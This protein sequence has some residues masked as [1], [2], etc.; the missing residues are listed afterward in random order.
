MSLLWLGQRDPVARFTAWLMIFTLG[1]VISGLLTWCSI[2]GQLTEMKRAGGDT[3]D[4]AVAATKQ[5]DNASTA[6]ELEKN[7]QI[8]NFRAWL[9]PNDAKLDGPI[10]KG[11]P[12]KYTISYQN[13]GREPAQGFQSDI[14][15]FVTNERDELAGAYAFRMGNFEQKCLATPAMLGARVIYP[16]TGFASYELHGTLPAEQV[17]E[18]VVTGAKSIAIQGCFAYSTA[19]KDHHS[20]Y[21][22]W[23]NARKS[24]PEHLNICDRGSYA[25]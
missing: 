2:Q 4:L 1:L 19:N 25:D 12:V 3:H 8:A 21:C 14:D 15:Q 18:S 13:T 24:K 23:F 11:Q 17:S 20:I 22:Y 10:T 5:A 7:A 9:G 16:T 6:N